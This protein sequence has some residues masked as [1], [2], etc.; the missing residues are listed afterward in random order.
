MFGKKEFSNLVRALKRKD[1]IKRDIQNNSK[2][3]A[4]CLNLYT[5]R[6]RH[7]VIAGKCPYDLS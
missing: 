1:I 5:E 7:L 2:L 4:I 3:K 6:F